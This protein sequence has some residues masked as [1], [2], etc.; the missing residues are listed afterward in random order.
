MRICSLEPNCL[1]EAGRVLARSFRDSPLTTAVMG[2]S[3]EQREAAILPSVEVSLSLALNRGSLLKAEQKGGRPE[4]ILVGI[5][6]GHFPLPPLN[7][8]GYWRIIRSQGWRATK[9][10]SQVFQILEGSHPSLPH[11]YLSML[12]VDPDSQRTGVGGLLLA[13]WLDLVD[14]EEGQAYLETDTKE[15]L[16][17]YEKRGF[18][19]I[20]RLEFYET[21]VWCMR[22]FP[23]GLMRLESREIALAPLGVK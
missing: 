2:R 8:L 15:A 14:Q 5:A 22:R 7:F 23:L 4:G 3:P 12:G 20:R 9:R 16:G 10:W 13:S 11:W 21:S 17:F 1:F 19:V 6:P 18:Q